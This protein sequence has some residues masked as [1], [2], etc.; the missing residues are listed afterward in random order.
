MISS[1][2]VTNFVTSPITDNRS[3]TDWL[4]LSVLAITVALSWREVM[5]HVTEGE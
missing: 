1:R 4:L 3:V 5:K 2:D